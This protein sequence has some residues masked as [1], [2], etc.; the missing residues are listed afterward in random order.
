MAA[1][2]VK[3]GDSARKK[4]LTGVNVLADAVKA[5]L[6][7]KGRNVIIEKSFG[8][9]TITKDG[10]SVAKEIE[11]ED[12]FENMGAQL[13]KDV[14]SRANDDAGDGT[15]TATV[16]AQAIVNEGYKAVAAGM[17][18]MDLKRGIDKATIAVVA[19]LKNLS[20]PCADTKA[21]A[22]V[23]T[24]SANSD[25]SIG[26]IIAEAMEK[27]GKEGV[28]T[29]EEGSGLENELSVVEG[30]QFDRGYLSPYFV[31]KPETM[32]AE[33]DSPLILLVDKKISN[34][35]EMLPVLE[36]VA[37]AGRPLL[38]VSEDV[39]GEALATL[40]VNNMRGIVKVAAVKAPGFGDRRKSMLQDI[41]VLTGGTVI[42]EE[43][44][45]SLE[46]ATLENLGSAKRVTISKE[47]TIIVD[48]AGVEGDIQ[49]RI[50]QI[51]AQVA[52][53]SSDYDREKLQ[54]RLAKL[55][56]GVAVIKVGAGSEV[57]MKEKKARVED[58]LHATRAAVEE[59]V[60]PGGGV[61]LIRALEALTN[62]TG[63][64]ADQNV[65]IAV[66]RRAVEAPLRQIAANSG[67]EPSVVV[68]E[69]K[70]GNGNYGYNAATGV[71]GDMIE[72]G[73]L[74]PTKVTRSA[75]QAA[76]SIGGLILTT[77]AAIADKP[78]AEGSA[79]GG[80]PDMGGMGG[81]GGMM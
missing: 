71:Y 73:I 11:L 41:A 46:S 15:T 62:L 29:V 19:E 31:N 8:A 60:V 55:S 53:T 42:S 5:T 21:I 14:A 66:L 9:P 78:K 79:G 2:E 57:E 17:N 12:R 52:E 1:K 28:I 80:M 20:K 81:M 49:S 74:D 40:V 7:P 25:S 43:I 10:V 36:A 47:N 23:G 45:L 70:N 30:M 34:I 26:D 4:M 18:P 56:G 37:K 64:N 48:G 38:I 44:G 24:I 51:R 39:E 75:L 32:V 50:N 59:G 6:G 61:A 65:G 35:R 27:V 77:E 33:L 3:F 69:V 58:A 76:A 13:V 63:D 68:N 54:E 22:Q 67:D 16:L 72:M